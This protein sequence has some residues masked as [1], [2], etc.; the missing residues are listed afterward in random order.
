MLIGMTLILPGVSESDLCASFEFSLSAIGGLD[1]GV[2]F[3]V[4]R[5]RVQEF[6]CL[7]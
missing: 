7:E 3:A 2:A 5:L 6:R 4:P 1:L